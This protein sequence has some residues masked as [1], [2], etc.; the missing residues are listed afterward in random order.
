MWVLYMLCMLLCMLCVIMYVCYMCVMCYYMGVIYGCYVCYYIYVTIFIYVIIYLLLYIYML[1][2]LLYTYIMLLCVCYICYY[3][4]LCVCYYM[5]FFFPPLSLTFLP[6]FTVGPNEH[7]FYPHQL[8]QLSQEQSTVLTVQWDHLTTFNCNMA[9]QILQN[10]ERFQTHLQSAVQELAQSTI[11]H[12]IRPSQDSREVRTIHLAF[13]PLP[14]RSVYVPISYIVFIIYSL[15][16]LL[17]YT[18]WLGSPSTAICVCYC[19]N[20]LFISYYCY[21]LLYITT[22]LLLLSFIV[23]SL[24][25][26][27]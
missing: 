12:F 9:D 1:C 22:S 10:Y 8:V 23:F 6:R 17:L 21:Y 26:L 20:I 14:Q 18:I 2:L 4:L 24:I 19:F 11:P 16:F 27:V 15:M 25:L 5:L 7:A 13:A 3:M